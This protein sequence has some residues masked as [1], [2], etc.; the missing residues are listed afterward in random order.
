MKF[1]VL[2]S[3]ILKKEGPFGSKGFLPSPV[4]FSTISLCVALVLSISVWGQTERP[5]NPVSSLDQNLYV[6]VQ[7]PSST[8]GSKFRAG[9]ILEGGLAR[10]LYSSERKL[11]PAGSRVKLTV[12]SIEKRHRARDDH[13][14]WIVKVFTPR[15]QNSPLFRNARIIDSST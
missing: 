3:P 8:K 12:E 10:D 9:D 1:V 2:R 11:F 4:G 5:S 13:W 14:P 15:Y 7:L 6:K